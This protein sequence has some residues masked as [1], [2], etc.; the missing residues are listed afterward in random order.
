MTKTKVKK[1]DL[2]TKDFACDCGCGQKLRAVWLGWTNGKM[3][4]IGVMRRGEKRPKVG[5]VLETKKLGDLIK[6]I[7]KT[8]NPKS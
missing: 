8:P 7:T 1:I 4:N 5:V 2:S 6:W 3:L